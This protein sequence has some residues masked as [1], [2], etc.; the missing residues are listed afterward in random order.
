MSKEKKALVQELQD[1]QDRLL[2]FLETIDEELFVYQP[3]NNSWSIAGLVEHIILSESGIVKG[4]KKYGEMPSEKAVIS[5]LDPKQIR[6][7][8]KDRSKTY[9]SPSPFIPKGI[10]NNKGM[11][12]EGFITHRAS[13]DK[14]ITTTEL[15]LK[16]ISFP[17]FAFGVLDG[18]SWLLFMIGHCDR[19]IVQME[20]IKVNRK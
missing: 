5:A 19:H 10:F 12:I 13:L 8:A 1:N 6:E 16:Q 2:H 14:F 7:V 9:S 11:A 3:P 4:I 17:H 20:E 18:R 15:P